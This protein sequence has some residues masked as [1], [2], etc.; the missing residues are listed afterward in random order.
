VLIW[1]GHVRNGDISEADARPVVQRLKEGKLSLLALHSA[2]WATP[3]VLAMQERAASDA[4]AMLPEAERGRAKVEFLGKI[5]RRAPG[6][7]APLT[8]SAIFEKQQDST[9]LIKIT[10]PNCCFPAYK[11]HGQ[12][13]EMRTLLPDHPIAKGIPKTFKLSHTEMYDEPFHVPEPDV[14][15]FDEHWEEG[16]H[17][18]SGMIWQVGKGRACYFRPGHETHAVYTEKLPM[19]IL[20]NTVRWLGA[21]QP[22]AV[23]LEVGKAIP[24]FDGKTLNGWTTEDGK[25]VSHGWKVEDGAIFRES[26]GGNILYGHEVGDF[27]L[28]FEW[29]IVKGGNNGLKYRVRKYGGRLLGCEYQLLGETGKNLS[30]SSCGSLYAMYEPNKNKKLNPIGEWNSAKIVVEGLKIEHWMNGEKIVNADLASQE[31]RRRLSQSKFAPHQDF[32]RHAQGRIMLT[33][34]GSQVWYRDLVLTPL[35]TKEIPPLAQEP[36]NVVI[37]LTDDQST[38]DVNCYGSDD[39][40]TPHMDH[41]AKDGVRFTQA[42]AHTVCCPSRALLLTGRRP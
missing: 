34:H 22:A 13:S 30:K 36:P 28:T 31:W 37:S 5:V 11:N 41:I 35:A 12:P 18:R 25:L 2:H 3:F 23:E 20:E 8:P 29:K 4:L 10:R 17:F 39:L 7:D 38:L 26:R 40:F 16:H 14:V 19:Q 27:E 42:Y 24:L 1:W 33:D 21:K 15:V 6:R 9:T 32:A